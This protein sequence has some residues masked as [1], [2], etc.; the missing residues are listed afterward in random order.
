M[1]SI[2]LHSTKGQL[3]FLQP[4]P[5]HLKLYICSQHWCIVTCHDVVFLWCQ[6]D[7]RTYQHG[8]IYLLE[9]EI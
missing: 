5:K 8:C 4:N 9:Q 2:V 6:D 3:E 1:Y 7:S